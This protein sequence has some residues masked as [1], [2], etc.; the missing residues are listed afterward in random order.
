MNTM[1]TCSAATIQKIETHTDY[2]HFRG[3]PGWL[4]TALW[5]ALH[6]RPMSLKRERRMC[7]ALGLEPI[8]RKR[9]WRP[10]L[11]VNLSADQKRR[12]M[13]ITEE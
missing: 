3:R 5:D 13:K 11:P 7:A 6:N 2:P 10:C 12:I 8:T 9:Y 1:R 4:V